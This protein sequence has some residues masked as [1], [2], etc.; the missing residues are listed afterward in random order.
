M[1]VILADMILIYLLILDALLHIFIRVFCLAFSDGGGFAEIY[2]SND[3]Y[4]VIMV[5]SA[6]DC[7]CT[8]FPVGRNGYSYS[9]RIGC[10]TLAD[11]I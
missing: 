2:G 7:Y 11:P 6:S 9:G 5:R 1:G 4:S 10:Y 3:A 8:V